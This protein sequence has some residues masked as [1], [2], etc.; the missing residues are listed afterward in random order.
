M[1]KSASPT[2]KTGPK[3]L[4]GSTEA[5][6]RASVFLE[7]L[8]GVLGPQAASE[9]LQ[10]A[11][12]RYYQ[13]EVRVLQAIVD[14][15]EPRPRGRRPDLERE[16]SKKDKEARRLERELRRYQTLHRASQ[17]ALGISSSPPPKAGAQSG[18][19]QKKVRRRRQRSR[20]ERLA[21]AL[22]SDAAGTLAGGEGTPPT[23]EEEATS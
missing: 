2:R 21:E 1:T 3:A 10:M 23:L 16:L 14:A 18:E 8:S 22:R 20:G 9:A 6:R 11:L 4:T 7:A 15:L 5:R 12:P 13:L 19:R 17:R